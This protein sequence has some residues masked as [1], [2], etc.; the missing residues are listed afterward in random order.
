MRNSSPRVMGV[1]V[2]A[3]AGEKL[4]NDGFACYN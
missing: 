2:K 4:K 1:G 3:Q